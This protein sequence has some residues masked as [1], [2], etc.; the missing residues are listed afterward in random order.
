[1]RTSRFMYSSARVRSAALRATELCSGNGYSIGFHSVKIKTAMAT[2]GLRLV[3]CVY[4]PS[5]HNQLVSEL[6]NETLKE[7]RTVTSPLA[8]HILVR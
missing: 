2:Q 3:P 7:T 8:E 1:M 6:V 5:E 4:K